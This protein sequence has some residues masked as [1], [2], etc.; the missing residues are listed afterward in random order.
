MGG[1]GLWSL[2]GDVPEAKLSPEEARRVARRAVL[3]TVIL[4]VGYGGLRQIPW[5]PLITE[6]LG[7]VLIAGFYLLPG[8]LLRD[9]PELA[10]RWQ[11]GPDVPIPPWSRSGL[12][13]AL[14]AALAIFPAFALGTWAFY[15]QVCQG[16]LSLLSPVL[17]VEGMTPAAG[18]LERFLSRQ[19]RLYPGHFWPGDLYVP[20]E[21][22]EYYGLGFLRAVA[23]GL[24]AVALP[25]EVFHRGY[26]M[27]ALEQRWPPTRK[28]FGVPFGWAA[29]L[30]SVLFALGHLVAVPNTARLATFFPALVFA[31]LWR[32]S[33]SLWAPALFH[34]ASNLLMDMLL[35][36]TF[37]PR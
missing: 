22:V 25:E 10:R 4:Y 6:S 37:P 1:R 20:A 34:V 5:P 35:A 29:V 11:V 33:N 32:R 2:V 14:L 30:S 36:S 13:W 8:W 28:L 17:W 31:W 7:I 26:L 3:A 12:R 23:V 18:T 9:Q 27:S 15:W 19:C 16:D 24:F 21:W